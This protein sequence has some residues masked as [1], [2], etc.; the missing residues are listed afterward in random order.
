MGDRLRNHNWKDDIMAPIHALSILLEP[1]YKK[2][3]LR[4]KTRQKKWDEKINNVEM[5]RRYH[6]FPWIRWKQ[7]NGGYPK[8]M[9]WDRVKKARNNGLIDNEN[10]D[11]LLDMD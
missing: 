8:N 5:N 11:R 4:D 9:S 1:I 10:I 6:R 7:L 2:S 3:K